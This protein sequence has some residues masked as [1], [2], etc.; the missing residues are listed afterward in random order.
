MHRRSCWI[1]RTMINPC[2]CQQYCTGLVSANVVRQR[3]ICT[4]RGSAHSRYADEWNKHR[5]AKHRQILLRHGNK[6]RFSTARSLLSCDAFLICD[7]SIVTHSCSLL[8]DIAQHEEA[9]MGSRG[10]HLPLELAELDLHASRCFIP[11]SPEQRPPTMA[12][13][14]RCSSACPTLAQSP[15][16]D[17]LEVALPFPSQQRVECGL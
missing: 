15:G 7:T 10:S 14:P 3:L 5:R 8:T 17:P 12:D 13:Y 11:E 2:D 4:L 1:C 16:S 9:S 6:T